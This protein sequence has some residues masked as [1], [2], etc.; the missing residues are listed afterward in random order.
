MSTGISLEPS[1]T[2]FISG[3]LHIHVSN[4]P[5]SEVQ[6]SSAPPQATGQVNPGHI[7][8]ETT[9][10]SPTIGDV[11]AVIEK[12]K[13]LGS[14]KRCAQNN[15]GGSLCTTM[16]SY[17]SAA[18]SV[19][20]PLGITTW[21]YLA[22]QWAEDIQNACLNGGRVGGQITFFDTNTIEVIHSEH[23]ANRCRRDVGS[24]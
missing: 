23:T 1:P 2:L 21:C 5:L 17:G 3:S 8:C 13:G 14:E 16:V 7:T 20:G 24:F 22:A 4:K 10:G 18:I 11:T 9:N 19:C 15:L 6:V 12:L